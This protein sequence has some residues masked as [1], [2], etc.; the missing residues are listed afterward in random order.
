VWTLLNWIFDSASFS[1][2]EPSTRMAITREC[3]PGQILA[4][5][6][7]DSN[8][9]SEQLENGFFTPGGNIRPAPHKNAHHKQKFSI[10][11]KVL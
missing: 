6:T 10:T 11:L 1:K 2:L 9:L 4:F 5:N 7:L 3:A 8:A